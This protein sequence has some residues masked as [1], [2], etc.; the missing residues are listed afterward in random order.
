MNPNIKGILGY[1]A[2]YNCVVF[3]DKDFKQSI[4]IPMGTNGVPLLVVLSLNQQLC[5]FINLDQFIER[6]WFPCNFGIE[7]RRGCWLLP[8][9]GS[10]L[11]RDSLF[12]FILRSFTPSIFILFLRTWSM[13]TPGY[14]YI[15]LYYLSK[16]EFV[17]KRLRNKQKCHDLQPYIDTSMMLYR[18]TFTIFILMF[19]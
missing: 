19:I 6:E 18:L 1:L 13:I 16:D 3:G 12:F 9:S 4:G 7:W 8:D 10:Y 14:F 11:V 5:M 17:Q 2:N 15:L